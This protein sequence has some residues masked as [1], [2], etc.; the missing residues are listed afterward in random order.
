VWKTLWIIE[1]FDALAV[2][3][4]DFSALRA[5]AK[6]ENVVWLGHSE[7]RVERSR[8]FRGN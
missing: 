3:G 4:A 8:L 5:M 7:E 2:S 1:V 6:A